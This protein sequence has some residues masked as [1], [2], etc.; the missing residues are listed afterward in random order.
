MKTII[1]GAVAAGAKA[2]MK[3]KRLLPES[4]ITIYTQDT[5]VSYSSCGLPYYIKGDFDDFNYLL[6]KSPEEFEKDG[7]KVF[8]KHRVD[9]IQP[10]YNKVLV[11]D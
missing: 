10:Q 3:L 9:K 8:L 2:A 6:V 11:S 7:I 5:H 4:E 1:I